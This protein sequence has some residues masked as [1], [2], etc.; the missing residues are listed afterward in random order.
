[1]APLVHP[2]PPPTS[3]A[4]PPARPGR[5]PFSWFAA[6]VRRAYDKQ[7]DARGL[8]IFR[9]G[10]GLLL[11]LEILFVLYFYPLIFDI[12][13]GVERYE[14][15]FRI[16]LIAWLGSVLCITV[17]LFTRAAKVIN[18]LFTLAFFS[19]MEAYEYHMTWSWLLTNFLLLFIPVSRM[20]SLDRLRLKLRYSDTHAQYTPPTTVSSLSYHVL[21]FF[22]LGVIYFTS[23][24]CK[25]PTYLWTSGLGMWI[26]SSVPFAV[27]TD[28]SWLLNQGWLM[29]I[30]GYLAL[31]FE[32]LF[33]FLYPFRRLRPWMIPIGVGLHFGIF[34]TYPIPLF[35]LG[36]CWYYVLLIP[37]SFW[38]RWFGQPATAPPKLTGYYDATSLASVRAK[39]IVEHLDSRQRIR[40]RPLPP[41]EAGL[42]PSLAALPPAARA[43]TLHVV[44]ALGQVYG[45]FDAYR[46]VLGAIWYLKPVGW[47]LALPGLSHLAR[48]AY[49][50]L[51]LPAAARSAG[52]AATDFNAPRAPQPDERTAVF[53]NRTVRDLKLAGVTW[54]LGLLL[55]LQ[56]IATYNSPLIVLLR[57]RAGFDAT[58]VGNV[59]AKVTE[60]SIRLSSH[61]FAIT[62]HPVFVDEHFAGYDRILAVTYVHPDGREEFLPIIS[63]TGQPSWYNYSFLWARWTFRVTGAKIVQPHALDGIKDFSA[64]WAMKHGVRL[65]QVRF[66][67][68]IKRVQVPHVW[69]RDHLRQQMANPWIDAG[70]VEWN[71]GEFEPHVRELEKI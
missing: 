69:A 37:P 46:R 50:A 28:L 39:V 52:A 56:A 2:S 34:V 61:L 3:T 24:F 62:N 10:Y 51:A 58:S 42:P 19:T 63:P 11:S 20:W 40:F 23:T 67:V 44:D 38:V 49:E 64:F 17:G 22:C 32:F 55:V 6:A 43:A 41:D 1:M 60:A 68:K 8:A 70:Y 66:N 5:G 26:P 48:R 21:V 57:K 71:R 12:V 53:E 4:P 59:A 31:A 25:F 65:H 45:G 33:L 36:W 35:A 7:V 18:Y 27:H 29:P 15:D 54:G 30:L 16:V 9:I 13:P 14:V 47:L